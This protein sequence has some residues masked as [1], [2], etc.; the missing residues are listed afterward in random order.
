[1]RVAG[2]SKWANIKHKKSKE[3]ARRGQL[4][5]KLSRQITVAARNGGGDPSGNVQL[6]GEDAQMRNVVQVML[7]Q[8]ENVVFG[9]ETRFAGGRPIG[10]PPYPARE[11]GGGHLLLPARG[12]D[13]VLSLNEERVYRQHIGG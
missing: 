11:F 7:S 13:A 3:D 6:R 1:M 10:V 12:N 8:R 4:F 5:T 2:H 9:R